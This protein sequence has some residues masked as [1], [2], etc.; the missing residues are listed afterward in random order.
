MNWEEYQQLRASIA[1]KANALMKH[2]NKAWARIG[3]D[4]SNYLQLMVE[5]REFW[6]VTTNTFRILLEDVLL[7]ACQKHP[8]HFGTYDAWKVLEALFQT[9]KPVL[10]RDITEF[11][12]FLK[13]EHCAYIIE[14]SNGR[15]VGDIL[16]VDLYRQIDQ[17]A[18]GSDFTGGVFHAFKHF[19]CAGIPLSTH[20]ENAS[21]SHPTDI[22]EILINGFFLT[23]NRQTQRNKLIT[24]ITHQA[25]AYKLAFYHEQH[26]NV[27]FLSTLMRN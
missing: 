2:E 14:F 9:E 5:Q 21:L 20:P 24:R 16:R 10:V 11:A 12:E 23:A 7:L 8:D 17:S 13:N 4:P 22:Y 26:T 25:R 6:V 19:I 15:P 27:Y 1:E 18:L 3:H